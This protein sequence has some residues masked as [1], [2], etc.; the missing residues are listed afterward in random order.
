[1]TASSEV[2]FAPWLSVVVPLKNE[3]ENVVFVAEGIAAACADLA[4]F[5]IVFV[6]DGSVDDTAHRVLALR[7]ELPML[8]L[9]QHR[10]SAGQSAAIASGVQYARGRVICTL[11]GDGQN[12]PMEIRKLIARLEGTDFPAGVGLIAGQRV[13]RQDSASKRV[14]SRW[15]NAIR[16]RLLRDG[17]RDTGCGL[18]LIPRDVFVALPY[19]DHMHRYLPALVARDGWRTVHVDVAHAARHAGTS[20]YAN[21]GRAIAGVY[22]LLGVMWLIRRRRKARPVEL[23]PP[24]GDA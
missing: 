9:V 21:L 7:Q 23:A 19:F 22:D 24:G 2:S 17:T 13:G 6:D 1:M 18:K 8:R 14:A 16:E 5:E 12:P 11:D 10:S 15:A 20:N 4:P 3:A